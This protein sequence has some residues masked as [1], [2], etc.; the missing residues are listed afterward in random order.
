[1]NREELS[2]SP[3]YWLT[4]IQVDVFNQVISYLNEHGMTRVQLANQ[5]GVNKEY[6]SQIMN[7]NCDLRLSKIVELS[8]AIG[9][10]PSITFENV[11]AVKGT[12]KNDISEDK[13]AIMGN[14]QLNPN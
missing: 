7:G 14:I 1:M 12:D 10:G 8:L 6:I 3:E 2:S 4:R 5:L 9:K 11:D 13:V